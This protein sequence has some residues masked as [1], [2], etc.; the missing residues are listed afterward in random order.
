[1]V[2]IF[3]VF[4]GIIAIIFGLLTGNFWLFDVGG[5]VVIVAGIWI[6]IQEKKGNNLADN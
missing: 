5:I 2:L 6:W 3:S 1:M 4:F